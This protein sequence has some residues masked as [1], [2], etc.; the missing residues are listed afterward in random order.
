MTPP[1]LEFREEIEKRIRLGPSRQARSAKTF[2][3]V[4]AGDRGHRDAEGC[5]DAAAFWTTRLI[6]LRHNRRSSD[7]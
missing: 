7:C 3:R 5:R 2:P 6:L 4:A 1:I